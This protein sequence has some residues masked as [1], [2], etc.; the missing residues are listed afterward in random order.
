[1]VPSNVSPP[2]TVIPVPPKKLIG[3][4]KPPVVPLLPTLILTSF[5]PTNWSTAT[6]TSSPIKTLF[7]VSCFCVV[8]TLLNSSGNR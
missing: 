8:T 1:M 2:P 7:G 4:S 6:E 5:S 3:F